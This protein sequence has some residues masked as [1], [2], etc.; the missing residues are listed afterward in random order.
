MDEIKEQ[1][2]V[3]D[4]QRH[5]T[6]ISLL[7]NFPQETLTAYCHYRDRKFGADNAYQLKDLMLTTDVEPFYTEHKKV[8][9]SKH[10]KGSVEAYIR[11]YKSNLPHQV[12]VQ[13]IKLKNKE[14]NSFYRKL[15]AMFTM[16]AVVENP[17][18]LAYDRKDGVSIKRAAIVAWIIKNILPLNE[19]NPEEWIGSYNEMLVSVG[20]EPESQSKMTGNVKELINIERAN[21]SIQGKK[22]NFYRVMGLHTP[23]SILAEVELPVTEETVSAIKDAVETWFEKKLYALERIIKGKGESLSA[24][25]SYLIS[26]ESISATCMPENSIE[27]KGNAVEEF[28]FKLKLSA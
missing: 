8:L 16:K 5:Q 14:Q 23:E 12:I 18:V 4:E 9:D 10:G 3:R 20:L 13:A 11:F 28:P 19:Y 17:Q 21:K 1:I 15:I 27:W 2:K 7:E 22:I 6:A 24:S 25:I 26:K